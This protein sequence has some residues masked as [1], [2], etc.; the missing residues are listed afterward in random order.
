MSKAWI[1]VA[2]A[3]AIVL[4]AGWVAYRSIASSGGAS[5]RPA[6]AAARPFAV[7]GMSCQGCVGSVTEALTKVPGV[8]SAAVS[9]EEKKALVVAD[10]AE[11][12]DAK[13]EAAI[14]AAGYKGHALNAANPK[15]A[16]NVQV[17]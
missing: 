16:P 6:Q 13:I 4:V 14:A 5:D 3:G 8:Q 10:A 15:T 17:P 7:E 11:V 12:P 2:I 1:C 9:L